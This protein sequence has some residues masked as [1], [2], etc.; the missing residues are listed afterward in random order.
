MWKVVNESVGQKRVGILTSEFREEDKS[1]E[2][3]TTEHQNLTRVHNLEKFCYK[4]EVHF[5]NFA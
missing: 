1:L 4:T 3:A 5:F 2:K